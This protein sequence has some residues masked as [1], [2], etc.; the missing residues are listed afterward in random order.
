MMIDQ[1]KINYIDLS[2]VTVK[3]NRDIVN[4]PNWNESGHQKEKKKLKKKK[5]KKKKQA[6]NFK[7]V[8]SN[9]VF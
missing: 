9:K 2:L 7:E 1:R 4:T 5:K 6:E 3:D 8:D